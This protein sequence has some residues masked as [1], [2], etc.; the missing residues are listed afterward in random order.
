MALVDG[1]N[2]SGSAAI[3]SWVSSQAGTFD[4]LNLVGDLTTITPPVATD[5]NRIAD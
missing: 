4:Q 5:L 3:Q 2:D 1:Q